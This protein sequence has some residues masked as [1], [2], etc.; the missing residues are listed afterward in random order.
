MLFNLQSTRR[1]DSA[2]GNFEFSANEVDVKTAD[3]TAFVLTHFER[4]EHKE[5]EGVFRI[6]AKRESKR[7]QE[8]R[9]RAID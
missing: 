7:E 4:I 6:F 2:S 5:G 1:R 3:A 9:K 8:D